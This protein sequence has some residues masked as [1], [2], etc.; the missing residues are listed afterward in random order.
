MAMA[1][2]TKEMGNATLRLA[3][4]QNEC[5]RAGNTPEFGSFILNNA[6]NNITGA[7]AAF[8]ILVKANAGI[9]VDEPAEQQSGADAAAKSPSSPAD[10]DA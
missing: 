2:V 10:S 9:S 4:A 3:G 6:D 7:A 1:R 5:G 8:L